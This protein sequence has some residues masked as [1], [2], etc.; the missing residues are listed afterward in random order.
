MNMKSI[1][2]I[3]KIITTCFVTIFITLTGCQDEDLFETKYRFEEGIPTQISLGFVSQESKLETRAARPEE[4]ENRIENI[5]LFVFNQAGQRQPLL[6][7]IETGNP[8]SSNLFKYNGGLNPTDGNLSNGQGNLEFVCG[9]LNKATIIA[10][11]NVTEGN[12]ATAYNLTTG[13]L[14]K[15]QNLPDLK[16]YVMKMQS[17]SIGRG[18]LFMMTGYAKDGRGNTEIDIKGNESGTAELGCSL[19]LE[20]TDAKI[21]VYVTSSPSE[22]AWTNFNFKPTGWR[23]VRVPEQS[24]ILPNEDNPQKDAEGNYFD[25][26]FIEFETSENHKH[27]FVFYMPENLKQPQNQII[28]PD[29]PS[30]EELASCYSLREKW[31][32]EDFQ[33]PTK[34]GQSVRNITFKNADANATYLEIIGE[35]TYN[36]EEKRPVVAST[37]YYVHL[38]YKD[39]NPNDYFTLRNYHYKY[40]ITVQGINNILVEVDGGDERPGHEGDVTYSQHAIYELDCHYDRCLLEILPKDINTTEGTEMT[41]SV[42]TPFCNGVYDPSN[43]STQGIEDYQWIKFA[44]NK[45]HARW[46]APSKTYGHNEYVKYPGDQEY[47][48]DFSP[49]EQTQQDDLP[50]LLDIKQLVDYL[51]ISKK[52]GDINQLIPDN[53]TDRHICITAFIDENVYVKDPRI[54]N[55]AKDPTLWKKTVDQPDREMHIISQGKSYSADGNSSVTRSLYTFR[56]KSIRT[57]YNK[58]AVN[59]AWG[60]EATMET[61]RLSVGNIPSTANDP[62]NGRANTLEW[63]GNRNLKWT[64]V[65]N[66]SSRYELNS[67]Y[68]NALY[69]CV[70]RNRDLNGNNIIDPEEIRWYLASINQLTDMY[71]G[72]YALDIDSR[73]YPWEPKNGNFPPSNKVNWHYTSSTYHV[74][75]GQGVPFVLWAEEGASKGNYNSSSSDSNNGPL[76]AYRCIRNLGI[77]ITDIAEKPADFITNISEGDTYY[78]FDLSGLNPKAL[79]SYSVSGAG[80]Y[81]IHDEKSGD[82][83]PWKKF[84]VS[85]YLYVAPE[86]YR[87]NKN[88]WLYFQTTNPCSGDNYRVPNMRELMIF[89]SRRGSE[90]KTYWENEYKGLWS[91]LPSE[92]HICSYTKFSMN[93]FS[94]YGND[95]NGYSYNPKDGS[96]GPANNSGYTCGVSD[97][98]N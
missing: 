7:S 91:W 65:L 21:E 90:L 70:L 23:V 81:P 61:E 85:K 42:S 41:W 9:S 68:N 27:S 82:N 25:T 32:T 10:I 87:E 11:A 77:D 22:P 15:I 4:Y 48:Q 29:N 97:V 36:D 47:I 62:D 98:I 50:K 49:T 13:E 16:A 45:L 80:I 39:N 8:R 58:D 59:T 6:E 75:N 54:P 89:T 44:I 86:R 74:E 57:I 79:R 55:A 3:N 76:Y 31:E 19:Q 73:L 18:A 46:D 24:L 12:T 34:P 40:N 43:P 92:Y 69:A 35:L 71:I 66:T 52:R 26:D 28:V 2:K 72:E 5:Y 96:M 56:Q 14:D 60:L 78:E 64:D 20:R 30:N 33:D 51:K 38:G 53:S 94:P 37:K 1:F 93:G 95:R 83:L 17:P 67:N 88:E 84:R 63:L